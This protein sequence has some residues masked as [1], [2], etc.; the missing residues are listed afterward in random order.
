MHVSRRP[1]VALLTALGFAVALIASVFSVS[2]TPVKAAESQSEPCAEHHVPDFDLT[3]AT[4]ASLCDAVDLDHLIAVIP[5]RTSLQD[6]LALLPARGESQAAP[7]MQPAPRFPAVRAPPH[8][9]LYLTTQ[10]LRI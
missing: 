9:A 3:E 7:A 4:C 10:R 1:T 8:T 2:H 6:V 5:D